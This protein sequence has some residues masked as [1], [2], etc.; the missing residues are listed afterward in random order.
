MTISAGTALS[1]RAFRRSGAW[2][3]F[4][5]DVA[6]LAGTSIG[7]PQVHIGLFIE[8]FVHRGKYLT[9]AEIMELYGLCQVL[10]GPTSTQT[11]TAISFRLGG[12]FVAYLALLIWISPA[13]LVM[14][15]AALSLSYLKAHNLSLDFIEYMVPVAIGFMA[16][17]AFMVSSRVIKGRQSTAI[18]MC[19]MVIAFFYPSPFVSPAL[20]I[21]GGL[22]SGISFKNKVLAP[23]GRGIRILGIQWVNV[24]VFWGILIVA[25][26]IGNITGWLPIRL[27]ENFY[28]NGSMIFGG[29][30]VLIPLMYSEFV[31]FKHYLTEEEFLGGFALVQ[32]LPGPVFAFCGYIGALSMRNYGLDGQVLGGVVASIGIFLPGT[33]VLFFFIRLWNQLKRYRLVKASL[34]GINAAGAGLMVAA[35]LLML[36]P[37][38]YE[39]SRMVTVLATIVV[40]YFRKVPS[41][42]VILAGLAAGMLF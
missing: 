42:V 36:E 37:Y 38:A 33:L 41:Y 34:L 40:L 39:P 20:I 10:P 11:L 18:M 4:L 19:A 23:E 17:S 1:A 9:E 28:R 16:R 22:I 25:A 29:G 35:T 14:I 12:T 32:A 8:R 7:G 27:F 6:I 26:L 13:I 31:E 3:P 24:A 15:A 5:K 30:N 21:A 2:K